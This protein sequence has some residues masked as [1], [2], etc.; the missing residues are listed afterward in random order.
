M[1][2]EEKKLRLAQ[3]LTMGESEFNQFNRLR[4]QQVVAVRNFSGD[5]IP[6]PVQLK[7]RAKN[8][9]E[10]IKLA[11]KGAEVVDLPHRKI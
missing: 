10:Q 8:M 11:H 3:T 1:K 7:L 4:S 6:P 5:E 2:D 9:D